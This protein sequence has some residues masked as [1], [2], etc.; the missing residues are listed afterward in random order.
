MSTLLR[1][2]DPHKLESPST[3][4]D[5]ETLASARRIVDEVRAGGD[6]AVRAC[7]ERFGELEPADPLVIEER[8]LSRAA[9][10]LARDERALLERMAE[11]VRAFAHGQRA[12]LEDVTLPI[13]GGRVGHSIT[14]IDRVGCY[15]PGGRYP[16]PSSVIMTAMTARVA[17]VAEVWVA[18]PRPRPIMLAAAAIAGADAFLA[19][20]GAHAVAAL[21]YGTE[22]VP[23]VDLIVGP[24][25]QWVS[26][27]KQL[28]FGRCGI[29]ML[30]GPT[31]LVVLADDA[32]DPA[33]VAADLLAQAE[34]A[35]DARPML[36][37]TGSGVANAVEAELESQLATLPTA[38]VAR[39]ALRG[40]FVV[41]CDGVEDGLAVCDALAPEH[42]A[43][44][45]RAAD[46]LASRPRHY[47]ALFVGAGASEVLG[48]YGA[49]PNH[50]LP[51]G[52]AARYVGGLSVLQF[53]RMR[54]WM[55]ID[56]PVAAEEL[57]RDA[58][59]LA[60]I[61]GLEAH[62]RAAERRLPRR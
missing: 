43:L 57:S 37:T 25:S 53:L 36:V 38:A 32:A 54:T 59:A 26:A 46:R 19:A 48:D 9:D 50:V 24:G 28:V 49:G 58:A 41:E 21:A 5:D 22:S 51:T 20:G 6:A 1:R 18:S 35:P 39:E 60:R 16:L 61:E 55:R 8:A 11:R 17:G 30:A 27:A 4:V 31:E 45:V 52:G 62:A 2:V 29:D 33:L 15:A 12:A 47:G 7:A 23:A 3:P 42:L 13:P 34:H 14:P 44:H 40:G 56:D 10:G